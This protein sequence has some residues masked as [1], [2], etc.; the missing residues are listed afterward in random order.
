MRKLPPHNP[1]ND[2]PLDARK[3]KWYNE[4]TGFFDL[5]N[6]MEKLEREYPETAKRLREM[7]KKHEE[8]I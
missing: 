3:N 2:P 4:R 8:K 7:L 6:E 1:K 5:G